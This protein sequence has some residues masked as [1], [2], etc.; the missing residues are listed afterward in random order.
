[1]YCYVR[2]LLIP[3]PALLARHPV[4]LDRY[5]N[6]E[7]QLSVEVVQRQLAR[8]FLLASHDV[9]LPRAVELGMEVVSATVGDR[10]AVEGRLVLDGRPLVVHID[11]AAMG[12]AGEAW[13]EHGVVA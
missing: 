10:V 12:L 5:F 11:V 2:R 3:G 8:K 9:G 6:N 4:V 13:A 7:R 1:M